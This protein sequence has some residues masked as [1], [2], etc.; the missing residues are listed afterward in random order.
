MLFGLRVCLFCGRARQTYKVVHRDDVPVGFG[1]DGGGRIWNRQGWEFGCVML[2]FA[3]RRFG[4]EEGGGEGR[5]RKTHTSVMGGGGGGST[6]H[7]ESLSQSMH[8]QLPDT[9]PLS[10][11]PE[12]KEIVVAVKSAENWPRPMLQP[13][14]CTICACHEPNAGGPDHVRLSVVN[15]LLGLEEACKGL[16]CARRGRSFRM[17][18]CMRG[19]HAG[20]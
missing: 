5:A 10:F 4:E 1:V 2:L 14:P 17:R 11:T 19:A 9:F 3:G 18:A 20:R 8:V 15:G 6:F 13:P 16:C 12:S 7:D